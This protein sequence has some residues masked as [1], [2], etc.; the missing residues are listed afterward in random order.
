MQGAADKIEGH[1]GGWGGGESGMEWDEKEQKKSG[2][3]VAYKQSMADQWDG[4]R[5]FRIELSFSPR[6]Q[7]NTIR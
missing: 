3:E 5:D 2:K 6:E 4:G 7:Q 1:A